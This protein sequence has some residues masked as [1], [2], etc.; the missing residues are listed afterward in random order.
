MLEKKKKKKKILFVSTEDL[1]SF[2]FHGQITGLPFPWM[3]EFLGLV[4]CASFNNMVLIKSYRR[5][6]VY[7]REQFSVSYQCSCT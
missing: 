5:K 1:Y 7:P 2:K 3:S 6:P 4:L